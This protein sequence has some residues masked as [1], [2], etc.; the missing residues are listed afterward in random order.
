[1]SLADTTV[2]TEISS[3]MPWDLI[4]WPYL[5][6]AAVLVAVIAM[7]T[8]AVRRS[9]PGGRRRPL[10]SLKWRAKL[11]IHPGPGWV[12]GWDRWR[13]LGLPAA[14]KVAKVSRPSLSWW[15]RHKPFGWREYA[16]HIG[17]A[18]GWVFRR[19]VVATGED[20]VLTIAG[21]RRGESA[22][23]ACRIIDAPGKVPATAI[24]N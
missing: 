13:S 12:N 18:W 3:P 4:P 15:D 14:R 9:L 17:T 24:R 11:H 2:E 19:R 21:P 23:S 5:V 7:I 8:G 20:V 1:M 22:A 10:L 6:S 16:T